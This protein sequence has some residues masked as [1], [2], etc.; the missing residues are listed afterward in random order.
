MNLDW[1]LFTKTQVLF[2]MHNTF[3]SLF[4]HCSFKNKNLE[5]I[6]WSMENGW[7]QSQTVL[8]VLF[9]VTEKPLIQR[10]RIKRYEESIPR[11]FQTKLKELIFVCCHNLQDNNHLRS[12][13]QLKYIS[14]ETSKQVQSS[15]AGKVQP[16]ITAGSYKPYWVT[17]IVRAHSKANKKSLSLVFVKPYAL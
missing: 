2:S 13:G 4:L 12:N 5:K 15:L 17:V 10:Y 3:S 1:N 9:E 11:T 14:T 6:K 8:V 16:S 7:F